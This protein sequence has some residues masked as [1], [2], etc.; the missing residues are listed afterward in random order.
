M[1][2]VGKWSESLA[3]PLMRESEPQGQFPREEK[4]QLPRYLN[5]HFRWPA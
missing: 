2:M 5:P 3:T 4:C 1:A